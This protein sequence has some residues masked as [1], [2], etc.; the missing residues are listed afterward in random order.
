MTRHLGAALVAVLGCTTS[1]TQPIAEC[2]APTTSATVSLSM[3]ESTQLL[4]SQPGDA[5][6]VGVRDGEAGCGWQT[7]AG[8]GAGHYAATVTHD[9]YALAIA[10]GDPAYEPVVHVL[11]R[12]T[13]D[14]T[15]LSSYCPTKLASTSNAE[16]LTLTL[17]APGN[18]NDVAHYQWFLLNLVNTQSTTGEIGGSI[19]S[20]SWIAS[21]GSYDFAVL[22]HLDSK[23]DQLLF[24]RAMPPGS[25]LTVDFTSAGWLPLGSA[26]SFAVPT[27]SA[28]W[29][30]SYVTSNG[31]WVALGAGSTTQVSTPTWPASIAATGDAY[32]VQAAGTDLTT[33]RTWNVSAFVAEP[34]SASLPAVPP[35][36]DS[37]T[38]LDLPTLSF[39]PLAN[40]TGYSLSC[41]FGDH[42]LSYDLSSSVVGTPATTDYALS[43]LPDDVP[44]L[45]TAWTQAVGCAGWTLNGYN[46]SPGGLATDNLIGQIGA[47]PGVPGKLVGTTQWQSSAFLQ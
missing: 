21:T 41:D 26:A 14:P 16:P 25:T 8:D 32:F 24:S 5:T 13:A 12:T 1:K 15:E 39:D 18:I 19:L 43:P 17:D 20:T 6:W 37:A 46:N 3:L 42:L 22:G 23:P 45:S 30:A 7:L 10:C 47:V 36:F 38:L 35:E 2:S 27:S 44:A 33:G 28:G 34:N 9:R 11:E 4:N 31:T 40:A 29:S